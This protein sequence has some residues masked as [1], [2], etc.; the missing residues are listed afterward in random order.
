MDDHAKQR[1]LIIGAEGFLGQRLMLQLSRQFLITGCNHKDLDITSIDAVSTCFVRQRPSIVLL[2]AAL[3]DTGFAQTH[4]DLSAAIN[5]MG[6]CNVAKVSLKYGAR[7]IYMSS[8]QVYNGCQQSYPKQEHV[9]LSPQTVYGQHKLE[10]EQRIQA[11]LPDAVGLRLTWMYDTPQTLLRSNLNLLVQIQTAMQEQRL[12]SFAVHEFR[13]LTNVWQVANNME[14][15]LSLPGGIY[16]CGCLNDQDTYQ[17]AV[18]AAKALGCNT[19]EL[20]IRPD[21]ERYSEN[22]RNLLMDTTKLQAYNIRFTSTY[23][24]IL[25]TLLPSFRSDK[26]VDM[27]HLH[28]HL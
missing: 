15:I 9:L 21:Y 20:L 22:P 28:P 13:G 10:A 18:F 14:S 17:T 24:G 19:P 6:A 26:K 3:S 7:L 23:D 27:H 8:D 1:L 11:M 2:C 4:P 5:I 12:L 16:N 25:Q